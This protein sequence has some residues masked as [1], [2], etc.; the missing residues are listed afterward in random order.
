LVGWAWHP[1]AG[2]RPAPGTQERFGEIIEA[3]IETGSECP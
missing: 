1:G 3:W 2:R